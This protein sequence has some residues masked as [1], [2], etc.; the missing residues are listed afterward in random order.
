MPT[1][2]VHR[3]VDAVI[4]RVKIKIDGHLAVRLK[5]G[6]S[7]HFEVA[8]GRHVWRVHLGLQA[9]SPVELNL[10]GIET[11]TLEAAVFERGWLFTQTFLRPGSAL[12]LRV[13]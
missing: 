6:A 4:A 11:V 1:I 5:R 12:D 10:D 7:Q 9:S 8:P 2:V 3:P 13:V